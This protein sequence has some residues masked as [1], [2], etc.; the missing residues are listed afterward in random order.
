MSDTGGLNKHAATALT[1]AQCV[2]ASVPRPP[3]TQA[4][5][6]QSRSPQIHYFQLAVLAALDAPSSLTHIIMDLDSLTPAQR[7]ALEQLQALTNGGDPEVAVGVL[8]S[9]DWDVQVC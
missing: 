5:A 7:G 4:S 6:A 2:L 8:S 3:H 9:V 1:V